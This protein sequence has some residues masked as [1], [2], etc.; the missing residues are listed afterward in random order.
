MTLAEDVLYETNEG[1]S[2]WLETRSFLMTQ[3][4]LSPLQRHYALEKAASDH[5]RDVCIS[6]N[7]GHTGSDG[8]TFSQRILKHCKK[9]PGAMA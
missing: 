9:G 1:K 4:P 6:G 7:F 5:Q 3:K 2:L 8:S